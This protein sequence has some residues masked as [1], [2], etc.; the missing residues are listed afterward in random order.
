VSP[1]NLTNSCPECWEEV[2]ATAGGSAKGGEERRVTSP[3][4]DTAGTHTGEKWDSGG[5]SINR[6]GVIPHI[7]KRIEVFD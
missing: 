3:A 7:C 5:L 2:V 1:K 6:C 4:G